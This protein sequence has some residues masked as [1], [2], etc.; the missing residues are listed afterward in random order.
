LLFK[1]KSRSKDRTYAEADLNSD[2]FYLHGQ[3]LDLEQQRITV[4]GRELILPGTLLA[5]GEDEINLLF[6]GHGFL[7]RTPQGCVD[8]QFGHEGSD[9]PLADTLAWKSLFPYAPGSPRLTRVRV[10]P[11]PPQEPETEP[12]EESVE[13]EAEESK[14]FE[15]LSI[16]DAPESVTEKKEN[17]VPETTSEP[18][19]EDDM[20]DYL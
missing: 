1:R 4:S 20:W 19:P 6:A 11:E 5:E 17:P 14:A 2:E 18:V 13:V 12:V 7:A 15:M 16:S 3:E 8:L 9:N 10:A